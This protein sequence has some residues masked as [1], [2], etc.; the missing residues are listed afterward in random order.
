[1]PNSEL[2]L[3]TACEISIALGEPTMTA[4]AVSMSWF[5]DGCV[6]LND[7]G[8]PL[9]LAVN[10]GGEIASPTTGRRALAAFLRNT[11]NQSLAVNTSPG[12]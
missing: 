3:I 10:V 9:E 2:F 8:T 1:M 12:I 4:S 11:D 6:A 7:Q 5:D